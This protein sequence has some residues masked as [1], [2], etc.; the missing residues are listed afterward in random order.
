VELSAGEKALLEAIWAAVDAAAAES[1]EG[2]K[3]SDS[4]DSDDS[5]SEEEEE[6]E[7]ETDAARRVSDEGLLKTHQRRRTL[8][9]ETAGIKKLET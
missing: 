1:G 8:L 5:E 6:E 4:D 9:L 7:K 3:N 2:G